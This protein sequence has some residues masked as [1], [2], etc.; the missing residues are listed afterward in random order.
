LFEDIRQK[1][2]STFYCVMKLQRVME[3][4]VFFIINEKSGLASFKTGILKRRGIN[5]GSDKRRLLL[6]YS[7]TRSGGNN[8]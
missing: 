3:A 7:E 5:K 4:S 1:R 2:S 6:K 8:F